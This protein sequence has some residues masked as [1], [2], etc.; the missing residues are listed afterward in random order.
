MNTSWL[1]RLAR[2]ESFLWPAIAVLLLVGAY[3]RLARPEVSSAA[4]V[5]SWFFD[6]RGTSA[7]LVLAIATWLIARRAD[8]YALLADRRSTAL[9][10]IS[11][12]SAAAL[13]MWARYTGSTGVLLFSLISALLGVTTWDKGWPAFRLFAVPICMLLLLLPLPAPLHNEWV[14]YLQYWG[15]QAASRLMSALGLDVATDGVVIWYEGIAFVVIEACSGMRA[16]RTLV[17]VSLVVGDLSD[18]DGLRRI[19]LAA[20]AVLIGFAINAMRI[21]W[22]AAVH[23]PNPSQG[24]VGQGMFTLLSGTALL[25]GADALLGREGAPAPQRPDVDACTRP[26]KRMSV[27]AAFAVLLAVLLPWGSSVSGA[28]DAPRPLAESFPDA[29]GRWTSSDIKTDWLYLGHIPMEQ[30]LHREY[31]LET[32]HDGMGG[33]VDVLIAVAQ[34]G[35]EGSLRT[36]T[37]HVPGRGWT[38]LR[39]PRPPAWAVDRNVSVVVAERRGKRRMVYSW[40]DPDRGL[41]GSSLRTLLGLDRA[42]P[43]EQRRQV[44]VRLSTPIGSHPRAAQRARQRLDLFVRDFAEEVASL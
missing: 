38:P 34:I 35:G 6:S 1:P 24:H 2:R 16:I 18:R 3:W 11:L 28:I 10:L 43:S 8:R 14:W 44:A 7:P 17:L 40:V 21:A 37:L 36:P 32:E 29:K 23:D 31:H 26:A 12:V 39:R 27:V 25:F 42:I 20:F 4:A 5:D 30:T 13:F 41:L 19:G 33:R 15:T 22:V 9:A